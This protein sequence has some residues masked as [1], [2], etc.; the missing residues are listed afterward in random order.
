M[1]VFC[2]MLI[3]GTVIGSGPRVRAEPELVNGVQAVVHDS[4]VTLGEVQIMALPAQE[5][6]YRQYRTQPEVYL[7][8]VSDARNESLEQLVERQL[9]LRDFKNMFS[10]LSP[11]QRQAMQA[12][13]DKDINKEVDQEIETEIRSRFNRNRMSLVQTLQAEGVTMERHR[14]QIRDRMIIGWLR[15]KNISSELIVSPHRVEV[16]YLAHRD[17]F[18]LQDELK[19]RM[20]VLKCPG[21]GEAAKTEKLAEDILTKLKEGATF[22]EMATIHS[23]GS[24]RNQGG[25]MGWYTLT[26]KPRESSAPQRDQG[27]PELTKYLADTAVSLQAGQ[28]SGVMSRSVGYDYWVC[29]YENGV[30]TLGRHYVADTVLNKETLE[31]ERRF[32]SASAATNLPPPV[33]FYL[34]QVEDKR[35]ARFKT[36]TEVRDQ[37]E[38]DMLTQE[39]N[40]LE[41]QWI[42]KLK[43]KTF[44]RVF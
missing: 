6:L 15:H 3:A 7:K 41:K 31:E 43:K 40:R 9:I 26:P 39:R 34:M 10:Q 19:L 30:P 11:E 13:V 5:L 24:Q 33:E 20:I 27:A 22:S 8:K 17:Q 18:Q 28:H 23:E 44:V 14:Q 1:R 36:L 21:E 38:K 12:T 37:I 2:I 25:E 16:Y 29:Q 4:V 35:P 42:D 32:E